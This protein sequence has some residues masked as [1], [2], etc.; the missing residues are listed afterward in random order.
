[1]FTLKTIDEDGGVNLLCKIFF[2]DII[3]DER[4]KITRRNSNLL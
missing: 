1:V 2:Y 3:Y 4:F